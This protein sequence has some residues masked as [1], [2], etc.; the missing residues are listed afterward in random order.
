MGTKSLSQAKIHIDQDPKAEAS[1]YVKLKA[2]V[3]NLKSIVA[4]LQNQINELKA[5]KPVEKDPDQVEF[6]KEL[7]ANAKAGCR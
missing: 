2:D 1:G 5:S 3:A 7:F 4:D 6:M